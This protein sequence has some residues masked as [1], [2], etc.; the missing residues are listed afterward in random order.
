MLAID[1]TLLFH[2]G[3]FIVL[4]IFLRHFLFAPHLAVMAERT[5]RSEGALQE[6]QQ[7]R[8]SAETTGEHYRLQLAEARTG[9]MQDVD[10]VY[11]T[12]EEEAR[13]VTEA[14][15]S[16]VEQTL[17]GLRASLQ[18]EIATARHELEARAP[19]FARSITEKLLGRPLT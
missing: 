9:T 3:L 1:T 17:V 10:T 15:R 7:V 19:E 18:H 2:I 12:A 16:E 8:A 4:W 6:A 13:Q 14:A 11:R 5:H